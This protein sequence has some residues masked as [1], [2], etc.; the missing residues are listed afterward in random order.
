VAGLIMINPMLQ[1]SDELG[2]LILVNHLGTSDHPSA[3]V[4][5]PVD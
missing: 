3:R 4:S 1:A 5:L 2:V